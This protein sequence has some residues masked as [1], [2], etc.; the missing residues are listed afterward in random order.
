MELE[1]I[2]NKEEMPLEKQILDK[3]LT[4]VDQKEK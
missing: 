4:V 2:E 3:V 1:S